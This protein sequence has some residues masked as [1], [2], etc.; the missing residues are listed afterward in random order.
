MNTSDTI[1]AQATPLG[2]SGV[3]IIRMSG[4]SSISI[5]KKLTK[6]KK[7]EPREATLKKIVS[8]NN[9]IVDD[10]LITF[11][12]Q[13]RSYTG[14]DVVEVSCH[15]NPSIVET[16]VSLAIKL[17]ARIAEPG[18]YTKRA[19]LNGKIDLIQAEA[20]NSLIKTSSGITAD[21]SLSN[22][23]GAFSEKI[24]S[25]EKKLF[26]IIST[27]EHELDF[28]EDE[29][30]TDKSGKKLAPTG[31][32]VQWVEEESY[33]FKLSEWQDKLL[34]FYDKNPEFIGP[35]SRKNEV[36]SFVKNGL[37]DLSISRTT[38]SWG[39][40]VPDDK[41][42]VMYVW[43]DALINYLSAIG[44]PDKKYKK[45]WP[46]DLHVVGKDIIRFHAIYWPAFLLAAKL[47]PPKRIFAHGWWTNEG[48]KISKS[49]GNV[50]DPNEIIK[51]FGLD[52]LRFFLLKEVPFGNDGD[53]SKNSLQ[54]RINNDLANDLGNLI[55]RVLTIINKNFDG[56]LNKIKEI[57]ENDK[58][59]YEYPEKLLKTISKN[60][61][62]QELHKVI[63]NIWKL[64]SESN[65]YVDESA[66]W[67][68]VKS[69]KDRA[70]DVLNILVVVIAKI[71]I[72][73][74][75]IM[76]SVSENILK[77]IGL[78][79]KNLSNEDILKYDFLDLSYKIEK[80][81]II[82]QKFDND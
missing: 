17:G 19:F 71:A 56:K 42:H 32:E 48:K 67:E 9:D 29:I 77:K 1:I 4:P 64:I 33:F 49:L 12:P 74:A 51:E 82:F 50:I 21:F 27:L 66:P 7:L 60:Y 65:K 38:F 13:P 31:S 55:Q 63:E 40:E 62:K 69:N 53:F 10:V 39:V 72:Y 23:M 11:F 75:P 37:N 54:R 34:D 36:V 80:P 78:S 28:N 26:N 81:K 61:E 25:L 35:E 58:K 16:I 2:Y 59:L 44:Y 57:N 14:E 22:L 8:N 24:N 3:S 15:G 68:L 30:T 41:K 76:P 73:L 43:L 70:G 52:T 47:E 5:I 18:E 45:F 20:V 79:I 6:T 46:A